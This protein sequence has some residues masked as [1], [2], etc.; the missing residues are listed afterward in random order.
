MRRVRDVRD[1]GKILIENDS[2][3]NRKM[4]QHM[5]HMKDYEESNL[6]V[7]ILYYISFASIDQKP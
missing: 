7:I 5:N 3:M 4:N 2:H 6:G 1:E